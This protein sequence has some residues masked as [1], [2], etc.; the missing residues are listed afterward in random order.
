M[1]PPEIDLRTLQRTGALSAAPGVVQLLKA[2]RLGV[3]KLL[4]TDVLRDITAVLGTR[5]LGVTPEA[6][7]RCLLAELSGV[8]TR[9][10][11]T[12]QANSRPQE[13]LE[14]MERVWKHLFIQKNDQKRP[15][16]FAT[17]DEP[18]RW[19]T[20]EWK[21]VIYALFC[22][23]VDLGLSFDAAGQNSNL[24]KVAELL[25]EVNKGPIPEQTFS[26]WFENLNN[27]PVSLSRE[28]NI[29]ELI[30]F[31][32]NNST[33][34][35]LESESFT[36][37]D[38]IANLK[39]WGKDIPCIKF[40]NR[41]VNSKQKFYPPPQ[42]VLQSLNTENINWDFLVKNY[43]E[44]TQRNATKKPLEFLEIDMQNGF[45]AEISSLQDPLM[46]VWSNPKYQAKLLNLLGALGI[47]FPFDAIHEIQV[48]SYTANE[49]V[50]F[51]ASW[52]KYWRKLKGWKNKFVNS[53][54]YAK[55]AQERAAKSE[56]EKDIIEYLRSVAAKAGV[57]IAFPDNKASDSAIMEDVGKF[58]L[59]DKSIT[60]Q[61]LKGSDESIR[62]RYL[63]WFLAY[64]W[65]DTFS[66]QKKSYDQI[67]AARKES[68]SC[69]QPID[70]YVNESIRKMNSDANLVLWYILKKI[71]IEEPAA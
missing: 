38:I 26:M 67:V 22:K 11:S 9:V 43:D 27:C 18:D 63:Q 24:Q 7:K 70:R 10:N 64:A 37:D 33:L 36:Q 48:P 45:S 65:L 58:F 4:N 5:G 53:G 60:A 20:G 41:R 35:S 16:G 28:A 49:L 50:R 59:K 30:N 13:G 19:Q 17:D 61:Q 39:A 1:S 66:E 31:I 14:M 32:G 40:L 51:R 47:P 69:P 71:D 42:S 8:S 62:I 21:S 15:G 54:I 44:I 12:L 2:Q 68:G 57:L 6:V 56:L 29:T 55:A 34:I 52:D 23:R 46:I 3:E 25:R